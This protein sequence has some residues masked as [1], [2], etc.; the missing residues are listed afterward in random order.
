M[1]IQLLRSQF[2]WRVPHGTDGQ[3]LFPRDNL[4]VVARRLLPASGRD[5]DPTPEVRGATATGA[6]IAAAA[7]HAAI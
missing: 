7:H 2:E 4:G 6:T 1:Q 5:E 3:R